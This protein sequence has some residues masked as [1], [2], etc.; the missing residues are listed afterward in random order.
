MDKGARLQCS[1]QGWELKTFCSKWTLMR[2]SL[3]GRRN[4]TKTSGS[5]QLVAEV[6]LAENAVMVQ[7]VVAVVMSIKPI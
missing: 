1:H 5:P 3:L 2:T 4:A 6:G 7:G